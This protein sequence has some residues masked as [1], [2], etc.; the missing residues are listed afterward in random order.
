MDGTRFWANVVITALRDPA[1][2]LRGFVKITRDLTERKRAE[3]KLQ[4]FAAQLQRSNRE[5]EQFA[6]VASHDLQEPLRKIQA[7]G[8]RLQARSAAALDDQ[9]REYVERMQKS[10]TR[11]RTLIDDLLTFSRVSSKAVDFLPVDLTQTAREVVSDL[12]ERIQQTAAR[13]EV[14]D[15]P[16]V[17]ADRT[18]MRQLLQ[19]LIGNALKFQRPGGVP[20]VRVEGKILDGAERPFLGDGS[21]APLCQITV[22]DNG[23]GFEQAYL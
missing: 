4:A 11:M 5:L 17:E 22:H 14:A 19:N 15:L 12:E 9:G 23:I 21:S 1:G 6:S 16:T 7:F 13:V 20:L 10:A 18:Q 2:D 8:D 3:E